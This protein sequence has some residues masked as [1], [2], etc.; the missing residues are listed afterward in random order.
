MWRNSYCHFEL[1]NYSWLIETSTRKSS[2][3]YVYDLI[4]NQKNIYWRTSVD[5]C[6]LLL[7]FLFLQD[8]KFESIWYSHILMS[9]VDP[10]ILLHLR[11]S[12]SWKL[13]DVYCWDENIQLRSNRILG[14]AFV[15][16]SNWTP[17]LCISLGTFFVRVAKW[18]WNLFENSTHKVWNWYHVFIS[19]LI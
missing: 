3:I 12:S 13:Q 1:L 6:F 5:S 11:N 14:S 19:T 8:S 9:E 7:V 18:N 10:G 2:T 17:M 16:F 15:D 4:R